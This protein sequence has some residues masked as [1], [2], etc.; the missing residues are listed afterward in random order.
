MKTY[1][2]P[3]FIGVVAKSPEEAWDI[4]YDIMDQTAEAHD[5]DLLV[6][7]DIGAADEIICQL[8]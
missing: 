1:H 2:V 7:V 3:V 8:S 6:Y 4:A 5:E